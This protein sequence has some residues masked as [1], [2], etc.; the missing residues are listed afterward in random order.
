MSPWQGDNVLF[1]GTVPRVTGE[2]VRSKGTPGWRNCG[3]SQPA[4]IPISL[5]FMPHWAG[6][7]T[8]NAC[9]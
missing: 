3:L 6:Q 7:G 8:L 5:L 9:L 4:G 2:N 1:V